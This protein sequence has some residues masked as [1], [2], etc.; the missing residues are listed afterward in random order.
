MTSALRQK[1]ITAIRPELLKEFGLSSIMAVPGVTKVVINSGVGYTLKSK[2]LLEKA[3]KDLATLTGQQPAVRKARI[4]VAGFGIRAGMT[5]GLQVTL[6]GGSAYNFL[7]KL[8]NIV[9]PRL[10]D[11]RGIKNK[12]FDTNGNYTLGIGEHTVFPEIDLSK[13]DKPFGMEITIVT[14][15]ADR[16]MAMRLLE[17][18]GGV[19]LRKSRSM[20]KTSERSKREQK[21]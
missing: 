4:S 17:L 20:A 18:L 12:G 11:F 1:Y 19:R 14:S 9:L 6:R 5:V 15:K 7:E 10:R 16:E 2:D 8:F 21:T 3:K 13:V